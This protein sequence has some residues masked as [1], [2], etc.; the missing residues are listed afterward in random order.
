MPYPY[1]FGLG[2]KALQ[3]IIGEPLMIRNCDKWFFTV[4][5]EEA[6]EETK[7]YWGSNTGAPWHNPQS[8]GLIDGRKNML[9]TPC[10]TVKK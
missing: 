2:Y 5:D 4:F 7:Q 8:H 3:N 6:T 9:S 1:I 10:N